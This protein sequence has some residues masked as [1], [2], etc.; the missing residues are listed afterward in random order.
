MS[1]ALRRNRAGQQTVGRTSVT[2]ALSLAAAVVLAL[3][4]L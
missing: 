3:I 4:L 1:E 2:L